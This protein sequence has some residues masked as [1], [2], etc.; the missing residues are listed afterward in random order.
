MNTINTIAKGAKFTINQLSDIINQTGVLTEN[1]I[2][3]FG[4]YNKYAKGYSF[5]TE[6]FQI[7]GNLKTGANITIK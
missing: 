2:V 3:I 7:Q 6:D 4:G 5:Y 1:T